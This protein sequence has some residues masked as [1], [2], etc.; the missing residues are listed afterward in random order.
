MA[1]LRLACWPVIRP[2]WRI[3][4][5]AA[6]V[7]H[8][9]P[10]PGAR[11]FALPTSG[12]GGHGSQLRAERERLLKALAALAGVFASGRAPHFILFRAERRPAAECLP[13]CAS[14]GC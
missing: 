13:A 8:Q 6:A 2:G 10:H 9:Q 14:S 4:Q 5:G 1:G 3:R 12:A 7:Q 11:W